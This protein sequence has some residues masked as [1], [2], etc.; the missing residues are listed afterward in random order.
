[1]F[2]ESY[3]NSPIRWYYLLV[4][5]LSLRIVFLPKERP[6]CWK[7]YGSKHPREAPLPNHGN[8][9]FSG[10]IPTF[11]PLFILRALLHLCLNFEL[12]SP[13]PAFVGMEAFHPYSSRTVEGKRELTWEDRLPDAGGQFPRGVTSVCFPPFGCTTRCAE[14]QF[15]DQGWHPRA[16]QWKRGTLTTGPPGRPPRLV[17]LISWVLTSGYFLCCHYCCWPLAESA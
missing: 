16:L 15:Q 10:Y 2:L 11:Q 8:G 1:M 13:L 9:C 14:S 12:I 7:D 5:F 3:A 17:I 4:R 6:L